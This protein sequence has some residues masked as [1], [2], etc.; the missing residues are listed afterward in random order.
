MKLD[1]LMVM[2]GLALALGGAVVTFGAW[3]VARW[4]FLMVLVA[5]LAGMALAGRKWG[6][7]E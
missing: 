2:L 3:T 4:L 6:R 1:W 7:D 5:V